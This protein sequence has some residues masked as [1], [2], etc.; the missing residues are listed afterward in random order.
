MSDKSYDRQEESFRLLQALSGVD[1]ELLQRSEKQAPERKKIIQFANKYGALCAACLLCV[2]LGSVYFGVL[3]KTKESGMNEAVPFS[4]DAVSGETQNGLQEG[5]VEEADEE[6]PQDAGAFLVEAASAVDWM[7][8]ADATRQEAN[9][10]DS[11]SVK[12]KLEKLTTQVCSGQEETQ[13]GYA[14]EFAFSKLE[15]CE[16]AS[17]QDALGD[18]SLVYSW[19]RDGALVC[20]V[21]VLSLDST[22]IEKLC[23][24]GQVLAK[25]MEAQWLSKLPAADEAGLRHFA[26]SIGDGTVAE[27]YGYLSQEEIRTLFE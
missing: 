3:E 8:S 10:V 21:R 5:M 26:L 27:Y 18:G 9:S 12:N 15:G 1:P 7:I 11:S 20:Y 16:E 19:Y 6:L 24:I 23:E 13:D 22:S 2:V 17:G 14:R 25:D 4:M